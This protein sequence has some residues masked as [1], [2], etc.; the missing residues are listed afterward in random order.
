MPQFHHLCYFFRKIALNLILLKY[1]RLFVQYFIFPEK[2][3]F[4]RMCLYFSGHFFELKSSL[5]CL[6]YLKSYLFSHEIRRKLS[7]GCAEA[8][9][10]ALKLNC[11]HYSQNTNFLMC[12]V[13]FSLLKYYCTLQN[14]KISTS[15]A[16][17]LAQAR[18]SLRLGLL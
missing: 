1:P 10:K 4:A 11:K 6:K 18:T 8:P 17:F 14:A 16:T 9:E 7:Q 15:K 3:A 5:G 12:R 13:Y 2:V